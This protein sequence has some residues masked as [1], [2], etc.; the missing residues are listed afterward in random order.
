M[1]V[2]RLR[3]RARL[4]MAVEVRNEMRIVH[5]AQKDKDMTQD[6]RIAVIIG[7]IILDIEEYIDEL[8]HDKQHDNWEQWTLRMDEI[9]DDLR[10]LNDNIG[11]L[12]DASKQRMLDKK[13]KDIDPERDYPSRM[14]ALMGDTDTQKRTKK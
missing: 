2:L 13:L 8:L 14:S 11:K 1:R 5:Q 9:S 10:A 7:E 6:E 12:E 3:G 4:R